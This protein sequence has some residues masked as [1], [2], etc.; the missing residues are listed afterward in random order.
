MHRIRNID[1]ILDV[2]TC[3]CS[4]NKLLFREN[5]SNLT[6]FYRMIVYCG[7][8]NSQ[9]VMK[10]YITFGKERDNCEIYITLF[11]IKSYSTEI[12]KH[13]YKTHFGD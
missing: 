2:L 6:T 7:K 3:I 9:K 4:V 12:P 10:I 13:V 5:I 8:K 11:H 1:A